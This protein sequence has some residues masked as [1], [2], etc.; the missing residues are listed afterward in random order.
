L[1]QGVP[2]DLPHGHLGQVRGHHGAA[3]SGLLS[4]AV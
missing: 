4:P 3:F 2:G 1:L